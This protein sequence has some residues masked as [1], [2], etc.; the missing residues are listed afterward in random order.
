M[1]LTC[2]LFHLIYHL[3]FLL[4]RSD[5]LFHHHIHLHLHFHNHHL[6]LHFHNHHLFYFLLFHFLLFYFLLFHFLLI[7]FLLFDF[8]FYFCLLDLMIL[9]FCQLKLYLINRWINLI[10]LYVQRCTFYILL[11]LHFL[12]C[13]MYL[14]LF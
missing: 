14:N 1:I 12:F 10:I 7:Y 5:P 9:M 11:F 6:H 4:F 13:L 8:Q 3:N 2:Q